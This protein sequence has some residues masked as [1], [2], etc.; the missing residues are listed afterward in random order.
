MS[1]SSLYSLTF[2]YFL[3]FCFLS[4][5]YQEFSLYCS[6]VFFIF[7]YN[8]C[9]YFSCNCRVRIHFSSHYLFLHFFLMI[10]FSGFIHVFPE[11]TYLS[12]LSFFHFL[13]LF[14]YCLWCIFSC[15]SRM[16]FLIAPQFFL[17]FLFD[18]FCVC[19]SRAFVFIVH[20]FLLGFCSLF[21]FFCQFFRLFHDCSFPCS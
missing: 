8:S 3:L 17:Y 10:S 11:W 12:F 2:L 6:S 20:Y 15:I 1:S 5:E 7:Y 13:F 21:K 4:P 16:L 18:I 9:F 14:F 19:I